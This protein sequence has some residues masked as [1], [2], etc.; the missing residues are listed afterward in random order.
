MQDIIFHNAM[1]NLDYLRYLYRK[2][3][4]LSAR[5]MNEEPMDEF[6]TN[7][8]IYGYIQDRK[9]LEEKRNERSQN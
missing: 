7:L 8:L 3:F 2:L 5:Q 1:P 4:G 6:F 9:R